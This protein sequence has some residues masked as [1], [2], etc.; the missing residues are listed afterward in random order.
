M[1]LSA[2]PFKLKTSSG[3]IGARTLIIASGASAL[4]RPPSEQALI[5]H[6]VSSC[7][8][9]DGFF[10]NGHEIAV[11]GGGDTAMEEALFLTRF[12]TKVYLLHRRESFRA[13]K[14]MLERVLAHSKIQIMTNTVVD[15]VIGVEEKSVSGLH[16]RS[17]QD[18]EKSGAAGDRLLPSASATSP[19]PRCFKGRSISMR[20]ATLRPRTMC[21]RV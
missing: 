8:T 12:A 15:E 19:T 21:I 13:S 11:V 7:A 14:V 1:D 3:E 2:H 9:C 5:G 20:M 10:F 17:A 4:A 16:I 18:Q 6:G